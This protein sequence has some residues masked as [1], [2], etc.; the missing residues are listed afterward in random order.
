MRHYVTSV[1]KIEII[2]VLFVLILAF[3]PAAVHPA[4]AST[5]TQTGL[6]VPL[7]AYPTSATWPTLILAKEAYPNVPMIA[8]VDPTSTGPGSSSDPNYVSGI[9]SLQAAGITVVGYIDTAYGAESLSTVESWTADYVNWYHVN[10]IFFDCMSNDN[11]YQSY[12]SSATDYANSLGLGLTVGNP[13]T[14]TLSSYVGTVNVMVIYENPGYPTASTVQSAA[15]GDSASNFA[16]MAYDVS[17]PTQSYLSSLTP[18]VSWMYFTSGSGSDPYDVLPSFLDSM[19]SMMS[20][21]D[22]TATS[23]SLQ[24]TVDS[25]NTL[26]NAVTGYSTALLSSS[27]SSLGTGFTPSTYTLSSGVSYEIEASSYGPCTF[28]EWSNGATTDPTPITITSSTTIYA[29]FSG[30]SCGSQTGSTPSTYTLTVDSENTLGNAVTGYSTAL[31]SSSGSSLGTG[32]TPSTYTLSSGVSYE[33]EASSYGPCTFDEWSNGATTDPTPITITSSTTIYAIFS[34]SSCGSQ[35]GST[36]STY[37]LTVDSENTLGNAVTGYS[38]ALLSSS[39]SSLGTGFTPSTYT[40]SSGVSYEIEASSYG[41][42][43]F[44]E[45]SNGATTDPTPITITSS[46][47]IYAIFSGSSCGSQTGSTPPSVTV[48]SVNQNGAAITGYETTLSSSSGSLIST[49]YTPESFTDVTAGTSYEIALDSYGS[50]TFENWQDTGSSVDS[51]T[52]TANGAQ[53]FV[54]VYDCTSSG[55]VGQPVFA[56]LLMTAIAGQVGMPIGLL[57]AALGLYAIVRRTTTFNPLAAA[58]RPSLW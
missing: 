12:Y 32:F 57:L 3:I 26:G 50:C 6:I 45:W 46:T 47:T 38:T 25:E 1:G 9:K 20:S 49:G 39:G 2:A 55:S 5:Q 40:L 27:G 42:C 36:P 29:I 4:S 37:T 43:T 28:D 30:S 21:M 19:L 18:Y 53:T 56:A 15:M 16:V 35:T 52:V 11:G 48:E 33:I 44:D 58:F 8:V 7:Y 54:G 31:L 41:P 22:S 13:G 24:L 14:S 17:T 10:G 23:G 51:R 34:G